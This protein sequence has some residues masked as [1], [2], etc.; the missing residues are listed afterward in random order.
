M[1]GSGAQAPRE[2]T[3]R[4][5]GGAPRGVLLV[6]VPAPLGER[7]AV[8][9][10][11]IDVQHRGGVR[12]HTTETAGE[13]RMW[14]RHVRVLTSGG[15]GR[16]HKSRIGTTGPGI[17]PSHHIATLRPAPDALAVGV[18]DRTSRTPA[19]LPREHEP[20]ASVP[21]TTDGRVRP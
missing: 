12:C 9:H 17:D 14:R 18:E 15:A 16:L 1:S 13:Q 3:D 10:V 11:A 2:A 20:A 7:H 5:A 21:H 4:P 8:G 19:R 6:T